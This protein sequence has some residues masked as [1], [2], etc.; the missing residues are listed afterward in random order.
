MQGKDSPV[1]KL[2]ANVAARRGF[3][4]PR[5][6][7]AD[8]AKRRPPRGLDTTEQQLWQKVTQAVTP[9]SS[10]PDMS[11]LL[12][13]EKPKQR[14]PGS[15]QKK[16]ASSP[17]A[18][19]NFV[20]QMQPK[21]HAKLPDPHDA[22]TLDGGLQRKLRRGRIDPD[23]KI[24]LH[25]LTQAQAHQR[26]RADLPRHRGNGVRCLL[27]VTGKGSA[28][29]LARH[30]LHGSVISETPERRGVLRDS[31]PR[32]LADAEFRPH[33]AAVRPA[34]PRHGG[35]GAFYVWLRRQR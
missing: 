9:L 1:A 12:K 35:G 7:A 27:V 31:L 3:H 23:A 15:K 29:A 16:A 5:G 21:K 33:V 13:M 34:H 30:T 11:E 22:G 20:P 26:L 6:L 32:W 14:I 18:Q 10:R 25:G 19:P 2:A 24:D 17:A 28:S 4:S 8:M